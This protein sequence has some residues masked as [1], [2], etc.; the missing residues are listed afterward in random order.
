MAS[1]VYKTVFHDTDIRC[2]I[3][4]GHH[5][6]LPIYSTTILI[7]Y[8]RISLA[9]FL[10]TSSV[11]PVILLP[12]CG[13][14][15]TMKKYIVD[16]W[17]WYQSGFW[18]ITIPEIS[19]LLHKNTERIKVIPLSA[20]KAKVQDNLPASI[21]SARVSCRFAGRP[22]NTLAVRVPFE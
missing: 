6:S 4:C 15:I 13:K 11:P 12:Y 9:C 20:K 18:H 8:Y 21:L 3:Q 10:N 2:F 14:G 19:Q 22:S 17:L 16:K 7:P 1:W 5:H